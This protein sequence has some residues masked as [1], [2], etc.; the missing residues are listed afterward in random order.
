MWNFLSSNLTKVRLGL[1]MRCRL[2]WEASFAAGQAM[3]PSS[4]ATTDMGSSRLENCTIG[5][6]PLGK[7]LLR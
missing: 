2:K 4:A 1:L 3:G 7:M 5:K 6:F